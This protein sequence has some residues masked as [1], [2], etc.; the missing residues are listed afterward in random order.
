[1][2]IIW[3]VANRVK[4]DE[5]DPVRYAFLR[6]GAG[7]GCEREVY[8]LSSSR[9][10][11]R[12]P[13]WERTVAD[14]LPPRPRGHV[15]SA[16]DTFDVVV[17]G[18]GMA[19]HVAAIFASELGSSV[20]LLDAADEGG[21]TTYKSGA[22]MWVPDNS[23]RRARGI[24]PDREW[25]LAHMARLAFPER[26]DPRA[27][28]LGLGEREYEMIR[29]YND[30]ASDVLDELHELG[31]GLMEFPSFTGAYEA[32]V[33]YH[34]DVE[35]G[36]GTHLAPQQPNGE[37]GA[38]FHLVAQLSSI[39]DRHGI[40]LRTEHR[41][42]DV[43]TNDAGEVVGVIASTTEGAVTLQARKGVVFATGGY[44]AQPRVDPQALP[45]RSLRQL[46]GTDRPR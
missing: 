16:Q 24:A 19:G 18:A 21:G 38:G 20:A 44:A 34:S 28:R 35:H 36:F 46:R 39:A 9:N 32:M 26:F 12:D 43:V 14:G 42:T 5:G 13:W 10:P 22:G 15:P 17:V 27:E 30:T 31:L 23:L 4:L 40:E 25:A 6:I 29:V 45:R 1:M 7:C 11:Y 41:V 8:G 33:E 3:V 2:I 37:Y